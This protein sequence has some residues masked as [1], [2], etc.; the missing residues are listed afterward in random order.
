MEIHASVDEADIGK[1]K[2]GQ[3]A[4]FT[5]DAHPGRG[6]AAEVV[7]IRKAPQLNQGVVTYTVVL[8]TENPDS[9]LLPGMTAVV[10]ITV[11]KADSVLKV[12]LAALRYTP[13]DAEP[14]ALA[15][16][17]AAGDRPATVWRLAAPGGAPEPL[18]VD[19]GSDDGSH[20]VLF[21]GALEEGDALIVR[22][23][24]EAPERQLFGIR[25]GF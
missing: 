8:S 21:D 19:L 5:V 4:S 9:L 22:E 2:L 14:P 25:L 1:I 12:P 11:H 17:G 23:V 10:R 18:P 7:S 24:V 6:F 16:S 13:G 3:E 15:P 20:A